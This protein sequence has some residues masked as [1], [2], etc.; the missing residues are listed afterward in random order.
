MFTI[1]YSFIYSFIAFIYLFS[2]PL[3]ALAPSLQ[4][5]V[6]FLLGILCV[7]TQISSVMQVFLIYINIILFFTFSRYCL[8][9]YIYSFAAHGCMAYPIFYSFTFPG[10]DPQI[11]SKYQHTPPKHVHCPPTPRPCHTLTKRQYTRLSPDFH[12]TLTTNSFCGRKR[13]YLPM[14]LSCV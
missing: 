11:L 10:M 12:R 1:F 7:L 8:Q 13:K 6:V 4:S 14:T 5:T 2:L 9:A 3:S